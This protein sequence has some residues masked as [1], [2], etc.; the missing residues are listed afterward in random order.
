MIIE[1]G[2]IFTKAMKYDD[3]QVVC[4]CVCALILQR[5]KN[6]HTNLNIPTTT[7]KTERI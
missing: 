6:V 4:M 7:K 2:F 1:I 5:M 3:A